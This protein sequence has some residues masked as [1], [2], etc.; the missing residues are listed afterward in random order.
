MNIKSVLIL[1]EGRQITF[2]RDI[3]EDFDML[4]GINI[5]KQIEEVVDDVLVKTF[6]INK[7]EEGKI[8]EYCEYT[9][10]AY[11]SKVDESF[12]VQRYDNMSEALEMLC[13]YSKNDELKEITSDSID[14]IK[15]YEDYRDY[16]GIIRSK[17]I[18]EKLYLPKSR[19]F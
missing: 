1:E 10:V 15:L 7:V 14:K 4:V 17:M 9:I 13:E 2:N 8:T 18:S 11:D 5:D 16:D 6:T 3:S 12:D 19:P